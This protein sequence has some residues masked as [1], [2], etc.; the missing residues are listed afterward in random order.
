MADNLLE[1]EAAVKQLPGVL[2]CVILAAPDGG[3]SE[4]HAFVD[5]GVERAPVERTIARSLEEDARDRPRPG[6]FV[7]ELDAQ[8]PVGD[9]RSLE[10]AAEL[11]GQDARARPVATP[12]SNDSEE[13]AIRPP[14][15]RPV[16]SSVALTSSSGTAQSRVALK[17][18]EAEIVGKAEGEKTEHGL[19]VIGQATLDA[20]EKLSG[21]EF[22]LRGASLID[23]LGRQVVLVLV[24]MGDGQDNVGAALVRGGPVTEAAVR[25]TLAAVN[26][27]LSRELS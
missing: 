20:A 22:K 1:L 11:A 15:R 8:A 4:I 6:I 17:L 7:F 2:E 27:R 9:R 26:R 5:A 12:A 3:P 16:V 23:L 19:S 24:S 10:R 13:G 14:S 25:A 21:V 18:E